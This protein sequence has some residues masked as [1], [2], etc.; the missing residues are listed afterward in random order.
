MRQ[1]QEVKPEASST[2]LQGWC[3]WKTGKVTIMHKDPGNLASMDALPL[4]LQHQEDPRKGANSLP[5]SILRGA[6]L[7]LQCLH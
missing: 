4:K 5:C 7:L 1:P 6:P 3:A 2:L